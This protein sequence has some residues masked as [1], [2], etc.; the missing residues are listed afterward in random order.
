MLSIRKKMRSVAIGGHT[1]EQ[2]GGKVYLYDWAHRKS[3]QI[4]HGHEDRPRRYEVGWWPPS[5]YVSVLRSRTFRSERWARLFYR[6]M[7]WRG[8]QPTEFKLD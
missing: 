1:Y 2:A 6:F 4:W 3:F 7:L 5:S 8:Y